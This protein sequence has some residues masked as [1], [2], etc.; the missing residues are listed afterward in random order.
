M[1]SPPAE[2][3]PRPSP[4]D[5]QSK[6]TVW[7]GGKAMAIYTILGIAIALLALL[8]GDGLLRA[9]EQDGDAEGQANTGSASTESGTRLSEDAGRQPP[10]TAFSDCTGCPPMIV[11]PSGLFTIG[12]PKH[13]AGTYDNERPMRPVTISE[14]FA[15]GIYEVTRGEFRLFVNESGYA[16]VGGCFVPDEQRNRWKL[17]GAHGWRNVGFAQTDSHPVSCVSWNDVN[18]YVRWLSKK[19]ERVY[20]LLSESEWEYMARSGTSGPHYWG[21]GGGGIDQC[22]FANAADLSTAFRWRA[23]CDD[24]YE[25]TAPVGSYEPNAFGVHD[26]LGNVWEWV[27]DC[28]NEDYSE[29]P[30][31]ANARESP[32]CRLRVLRGGSRY[33]GTPGIRSAHRFK[34]EPQTRNQNTGFRVARSLSVRSG[35][36]T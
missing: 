30:K 22:R 12:S 17:S 33:V 16:A 14:P 35:D 9:P 21:D 25:F 32:G 19:S 26:V 8:F 3:S 2:T 29:G 18:E 23:R 5:G 1:G 36:G 15:V 28:W 20:R 10:G 24:G 27:Q 13:E 6:R 4:G 7:Y 34:Y 31:D 11:V